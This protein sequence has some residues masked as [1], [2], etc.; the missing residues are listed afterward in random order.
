ELE[1]LSECVIDGIT[2]T[3]TNF[4]RA[5]IGFTYEH[6]TGAPKIEY[7]LRYHKDF[8]HNGKILVKILQ[9]DDCPLSGSDARE[10]LRLMQELS[11]KLVGDENA[12]TPTTS[13]SANGENSTEFGDI[14]DND[15][16]ASV[17]HS[18]PTTSE[19]SEQHSDHHKDNVSGYESSENESSNSTSGSES[20]HLMDQI[21][22]PAG[23]S[24]GASDDE[25]IFADIEIPLEGGETAKESY[26]PDDYDS[27]SDV[28]VITETVEQVTNEL[29]EYLTD[30]EDE[31]EKVKVLA[32]DDNLEPIEV[33]SLEEIAENGF[34]YDYP[35]Y[36]EPR[37]P[38]VVFEESESDSD[39]SFVSDLETLSKT[40]FSKR[41]RKPEVR[42]KV[43]SV[44]LTAPKSS[45]FPF[46][47]SVTTPR[48]FQ[49]Y[50]IRMGPILHEIGTKMNNSKMLGNSGFGDSPP[51]SL[52][53][54]DEANTSRV[55]QAFHCASPI[56][57]FSLSSSPTPAAIILQRNNPRTRLSSYPANRRTS[58]VRIR[59]G[60]LTLTD[61]DSNMKAS[62]S[63]ALVSTPVEVFDISYY[64][65]V[66]KRLAKFYKMHGQT[67]PKRNEHI[68]HNVKVALDSERGDLIETW[69]DVK[70]YVNAIGKIKPEPI[71][72][73]NSKLCP[74]VIKGK[75]ET[76][77]EKQC[78]QLRD[79][80]E[81]EMRVIL[82]SWEEGRLNTAFFIERL[83]AHLYHKDVQTVAAVT[84]ALGQYCKLP[85]K[86]NDL[87]RGPEG[88]TG[89]GLMRSSSANTGDVGM[90]GDGKTQRS[91]SIAGAPAPLHEKQAHDSETKP[92]YLRKISETS[93]P[94]SSS[95][96]E[97]ALGHLM[98][99]DSGVHATAALLGLQ[100]VGGDSPCLIFH[101]SESRV[102][103]PEAPEPVE[104]ESD[105]PLIVG[106]A[107]DE[108]EDARV[109]YGEI[110]SRWGMYKQAAEVYKFCPTQQPE[111]FVERVFCDK[112][113]EPVFGD[114][115]GKCQRCRGPSISCALCQR[116]CTGLLLTCPRCSHGGHV[117]HIRRW[118][119]EQSACPL[120]CG[121]I[122]P[123]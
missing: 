110:L 19:S 13:V 50:I 104:L 52:P 72:H 48:T 80:R 9:K 91:A 54:G 90:T 42:K 120:G 43:A 12:T 94:R 87:N 100:I 121:C 37:S 34:H 5:A 25:I 57:S 76:D 32:D 68:R 99:A 33:M 83:K 101:S 111:P 123:F 115:L 62:S 41:Q 118:F 4:P 22:L 30:S 27:E 78:H 15:S 106:R 38:E 86:R 66:S 71:C 89:F 31:A 88:P 3:E 29:H 46:G 102:E 11:L 20:E 93:R 107:F 96:D 23:P 14:G 79:K 10:L 70:K 67:G 64:L 17:Q 97:A 95:I 109:S 74:A 92:T 75:Y 61:A 51:S 24:G 7:E 114:N 60:S 8:R 63:D 81:R 59:G 44:L 16:G 1:M 47:D 82:R 77:F 98:T 108:F 28:C 18:T 84:C 113:Q 49:D 85:K 56:Q 21:S 103:V 45:L 122:C 39:S 53:R 117:D 2:M 55:A 35:P 40:R 73:C 65:P 58:S 69:G 36:Y 105:Q 6:H 26:P 112:C 116:P 119:R